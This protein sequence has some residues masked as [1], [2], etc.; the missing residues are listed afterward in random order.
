[1]GR[2][3]DHAKKEVFLEMC[4]KLENEGWQSGV[5]TM[6]DLLKMQD[7]LADGR[8]VYVKLSVKR[9]LESYYG[10]DTIY[11][12]TKGT[13]AQV[14]SF[15]SSLREI[16]VYHRKSAEG[17]DEE[18]KKAIL[19]AA[20]KILLDDLKITPARSDIYPTP[21]QMSKASSIVPPSLQRFLS[22]F[23]SGTRSDNEMRANVIGQ[24]LVKLRHPRQ[25]VSPYGLGLAIQLDHRFRS[26]WL[27]NKMHNLGYCESYDEVH[28]YKY[29]VLQDIA[30]R[31][32]GNVVNNEDNDDS[33]NV[34]EQDVIDNVDLRLQSVTGSRELHL[35]GHI[36]VRSHPQNNTVSPIPRIK[37]TPQQKKDLLD[38]QV[39]VIFSCRKPTN[40]L[41]NVLCTPYHDLLLKFIGADSSVEFTQV[42]KLCY[43]AWSLNVDNDLQWCPNWKGFLAGLHEV[44]S[45][46][47]V[48]EITFKPLIYSNPNDYSTLYTAI[49][50]CLEEAGGGH[51]IR[52]ADLP[53]YLKCVDLVESMDLPVLMRLGMFH[54]LKSF[55]GS[56]GY[57]MSGSG[58]EELLTV[59]F[60]D[61]TDVTNILNG[62][63]YYKSLRG[64]FLV[65]FALMSHLAESNGILPDLGEIEEQIA[66]YR[67]N[68][69][70]VNLI[71]DDMINQFGAQLNTALSNLDGRTPK[72]WRWF[73]D[74]VLIVKNAIRADRTGN[75]ELSLRCQA[76]MLPTFAAAG[77]NKYAR[78]IRMA[79]QFVDIYKERFPLAMKVFE[80]EGLHTVRYNE[81]EWSGVPTDLAIEQQLMRSLKSIG[82]I[83][84]GSMRNEGSERLWIALIGHTALVNSTLGDNLN[85]TSGNP[86]DFHKDQS[87]SAMKNDKAAVKKAIEWLQDN[88]PFCQARDPNKIVSL[89]TGLSADTDD[90]NPDKAHEV[91]TLIQEEY[92]SC[93]SSFPVKGKV[94]PLSDLLNKVSVKDKSLTVDVQKLFQRLLALIGR[95]IYGLATIASYELTPVP[96]ALFDNARR[97][98]KG[99][100]SQ[101]RNLIMCEETL[102]ATQSH[103]KTVVDGGWLV[104]QVKW[105][106]GEKLRDL[107]C[108][109]GH[110]VLTLGPSATV[111]LDGYS[112]S[113]KDHERERRTKTA[114]REMELDLDR[115]ICVR[116]ETFFDNPANKEKFTTLLASY[117]QQ[118]G[119][120]TV[121]AS[122][123]ADIH[124]VKET[125]ALAADSEVLVIA[126]DTDIAIMLVY[127]AEKLNNDVTLKLQGSV[128]SV[129]AATDRLSARQVRYLLLAHA[130]LA[131]TQLALFYLHR[132]LKDS[133]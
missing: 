17:T 100:K 77:H 18:K 53:I 57:I 78:A 45:D 79:L 68:R 39:P 24:N 86:S 5:Y 49:L 69:S 120:K 60:T 64:L 97:M 129:R 7:D 122:A 114:C 132:K 133:R 84:H 96:M 65:D 14:I 66:F 113:T 52:T 110:Y 67:M 117:L 111:V 42:D 63:A 61:T 4:E 72:L 108:R 112:K 125:I 128:Y 3:E 54:T 80:E 81:A 93:S 88:D 102:N 71:T 10:H 46:R 11:F 16:L 121:K 20:A 98:R 85:D 37:L 70:W 9:H 27:I 116:R 105:E 82:G 50:R 1:M 59:I 107:L 104:Y 41:K 115:S 90:I 2:P 91:G 47:P 12:A 34:V 30:N 6:S 95:G 22:A 126:E 56:I 44:R 51:A 8:L 33:C 131:V 106:K 15:R 92:S 118:Q 21:E 43:A 40:A 94:K 89:S 74:Q 83:T 62:S 101:L 99:V 28:R 48:S 25:G 23:F 29:S 109:R 35:L 76:Q 119:I 32:T 75:W 87:K 73:H 123:D 26:K 38:A 103:T 130:F 124:I 55:L 13:R 58:Y 19:D 31:Q 36:G 127:H